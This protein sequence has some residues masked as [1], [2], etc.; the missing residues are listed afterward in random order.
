VVADDKPDNHRYQDMRDSPKTGRKWRSGNSCR[1]S[2]RPPLQRINRGC[3]K[4]P[5]NATDNNAEGDL[6]GRTGLSP[7]TALSTI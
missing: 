2:K 3:Q 1:A 5:N 4:E 6:F 7:G